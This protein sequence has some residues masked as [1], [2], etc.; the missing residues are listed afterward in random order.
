MFKNISISLVGANSKSVDLETLL[1]QSS[2]SKSFSSPPKQT[3]NV[4]H[5]PN[6]SVKRKSWKSPEL[7]LSG[8][9]FKKSSIILSSDE[10]SPRKKSVPTVTLDENT[11]IEDISD[12]EKENKAKENVSS[13]YDNCTHGDPMDYMCME[14]T[15]NRWRC[16]WDFVKPVRAKKIKKPEE[17]EVNPVEII[18]AVN[19]EKVFKF[20]GVGLEEEGSK[21]N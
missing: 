21:C 5:K 9:R 20:A 14:C 2:T 16:E 12:D 15:F 6:I 8:K 18:Q 1:K 7:V 10:E 4:F 13:Q 11:T 3:Q 17:V 19:W